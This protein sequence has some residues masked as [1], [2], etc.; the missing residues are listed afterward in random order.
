MSI[1]LADL[2]DKPISAPIRN[3]ATSQSVVAIN[4]VTVPGDHGSTIQTYIIEIDD[5]FGN[6]FTPIQGHDSDSLLLTA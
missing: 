5:G 2:P 3:V 1:I 6:Q 4:I